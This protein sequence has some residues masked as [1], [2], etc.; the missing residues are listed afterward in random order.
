MEAVPSATQFGG[1]NLPQRARRVLRRPSDRQPGRRAAA[2]APTRP[3]RFTTQRSQQL[4][5]RIPWVERLAGAA[6]KVDVELPVGKLFGDQPAGL[7]G[8]RGLADPA[9]PRH[10][11]DNDARRNDVRVSQQSQ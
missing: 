9:H 8:E 11:R 4:Q 6:A 10:S 3:A 5:E 1:V 7:D 2:H